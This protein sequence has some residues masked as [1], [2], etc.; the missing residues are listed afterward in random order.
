MLNSAVYGLARAN[1]T[2]TSNPLASEFFHMSHLMN[3]TQEAANKV[4]AVRCLLDAVD[5]V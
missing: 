3:A 2:F 1:N 5:L 4:Q